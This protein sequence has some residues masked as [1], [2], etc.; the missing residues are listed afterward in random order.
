MADNPD[1]ESTS[2]GP[3]SPD[4]GVKPNE[5]KPASL[6]PAPS[7]A[8]NS[9]SLPSRPGALSETPDKSAPAAPM[10]ERRMEFQPISEHRPES[11]REQERPISL[12]P[13][14]ITPAQM[15][16]LRERRVT[17]RDLGWNVL[18]KRVMVDSRE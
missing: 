16:D 15:Q 14:P 7:R 13:V 17:A 10:R 12:R 8:I 5:I 11:K 9:V 4:N 1:H 18:G 2:R 6:R 3:S